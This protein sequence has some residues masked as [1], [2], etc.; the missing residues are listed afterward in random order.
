MPLCGFFVN[1]ENQEMRRTMSEILIHKAI[2][3]LDWDFITGYFKSGQPS[4]DEMVQDLENTIR[5][6]LDNGI[7]EFRKEHWALKISTSGT[8]TTLEILFIPVSASATMKVHGGQ[9]SME[10][11]AS[12]NSEKITLE[13]ILQQALSEE[14]YELAK[15]VQ[16][17]IVNNYS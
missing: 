7:S 11:S 4:K 14:N 15:A 9:E 10:V 1:G 17:R 12:K 16:E 13:R 5:F 2:T 6:M 8:E 3:Q